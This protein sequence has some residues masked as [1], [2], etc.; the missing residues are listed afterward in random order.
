MIGNTE[1][2]SDKTGPQL[3]GHSITLDKVLTPSPVENRH[4]KVRPCLLYVAFFRFMWNN[5]WDCNN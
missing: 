4:T 2:R 3:R 5:R 1:I